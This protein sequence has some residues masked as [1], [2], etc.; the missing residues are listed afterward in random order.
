MWVVYESVSGFRYSQ[1]LY[2]YK[3]SR[4]NVILGICDLDKVAILV[5][6]HEYCAWFEIIIFCVT[7]YVRF[8][9]FEE[10]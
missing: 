6:N 10:R 9:D 7:K 5:S 2:S 3:H 8:V 4:V 1:Q